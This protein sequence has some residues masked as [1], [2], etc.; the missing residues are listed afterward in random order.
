[1]PSLLNFDVKTV[2]KKDIQLVKKIMDDPWMQN[3]M[4]TRHLGIAAESNFGLQLFKW[5]RKIIEFVDIT[6]RL[7]SLGIRQIEA[8]MTRAKQH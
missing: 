7:D 4:T 3:E 2:T 5:T 6:S 1:M 8:K